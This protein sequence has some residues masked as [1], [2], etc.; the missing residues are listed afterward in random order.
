MVVVLVRNIY[1]VDKNISKVVI[2]KE[3]ANIVI[4][5]SCILVSS[6]FMF[7]DTVLDPAV[8]ALYTACKQPREAY[9]RKFQKS[10]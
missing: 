5:D 2:P 1:V 10:L 9:M 3:N 7:S 6:I 8:K 4:I